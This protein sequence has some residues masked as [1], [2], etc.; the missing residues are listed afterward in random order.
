MKRIFWL[1]MH[2]IL[3]QTELPRLRQLGYEVFNPPYLSNI[4]DQSAEMTWSLSN[5]QSSLPP[6]VIKQLSKYNFFYN[7]I[8]ANI[9][10][11][12]NHYFDAMVVTINPTWLA[13][14][15]R[16][17]DGP[18][19]YRTYG[20]PYCISAELENTG[21]AA[22]ILNRDNFWYM[23]HAAE[24]TS[25]EHK[26]LGERSKVVPYCLTEDV[27]ALENYWSRTTNKHHEIALTCP[28]IDNTYYKDHYKF[29][30]QHFSRSCFRFYGV[31]LRDVP[32]DTQIVGTLSRDA[33]LKALLNSAGYLYTYQEPCVCYLPPVEMS[34]M[35]GPV[36]FLKGS[37][38]DRFHSEQAAGRAAT[39]LEAAEKCE[40]LLNNDQDFV[41]LLIK[42]GRRVAERYHPKFVWPTFDREMN[43]ALHTGNARPRWVY[44]SR[45]ALED[46]ESKS[47][48]YLLHHFPGECVTFSSGEYSAFDGIPRV[49]RQ[50]VKALVQDKERQTE[51]IIT[52]R[53]D[54][55][56]RFEGYFRA[57][58]ASRNQIKFMPI[59]TATAALN[60]FGRLHHAIK[61][62]DL[63][64]KQSLKFN[65]VSL[66]GLL[67]KA[68]EWKRRL[69]NKT[70]RDKTKNTSHPYLDHINEDTS[71]A[72]VIVP[73]YYW[74]PEALQINCAIVLYLPDYMPH[75]FPDEPHFREISSTYEKVGRDI[76]HKATT[77]FCNSAFTCKYLPQS[78]LNVDSAKIKVVPLPILQEQ[79]TPDSECS[80]DRGCETD[81]PARYIF[82]PTQPRA[83]KNLG[84]TLRVFDKLADND[85]SLYLILTG[86]P[87]GDG[88]AAVAL[89]EMSHSSRVKIYPSVSDVVLEEIYKQSLL[90]CFTSNGE[91]N[92]P[93]QILEA[94]SYGIPVVATDLEFVTEHLPSDMRD[95]LLTSRANDVEDF[96][97]KV[98]EA[99]LNRKKVLM[100]Q[101]ALLTRL[102]ETMNFDK[103]SNTLLTD[104]FAP[105]WT[106]HSEK[107]A[108]II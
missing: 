71:A 21:A 93:P 108:K 83:N 69:T 32:E 17:F 88:A 105:C 72:A 11:I 12:I 19:V 9:A 59:D 103:F 5:Q 1:G 99:M 35:G 38:L 92:F 39:P 13:D 26:W 16:V 66:E 85:E 42:E 31:Q 36:V 100:K 18:V 102:R 23:P 73:H 80:T 29:L 57:V 14:V 55:L 54:Q 45:L 56:G 65:P 94:L 25:H 61:W 97:S 4:R 106:S 70:R 43:D 75:L 2:K 47:R 90:L 49:M 107:A 48:V 24:T 50:V 34:I 46:R 20:S 44:R 22:L 52:C 7:P 98:Q 101:A 76:A 3:V 33:Q 64:L 89:S 91:G 77:V 60:A 68:V 40:R 87:K 62:A 96:V 37:L 15:L 30:K 82:Y 53:H 74:F 84:L 10:D 6:S 41:R 78:S 27:I 28:N 63:T 86:D 79:K 67:L 104:V 95:Y 58:D 81:L 51:V 8:T